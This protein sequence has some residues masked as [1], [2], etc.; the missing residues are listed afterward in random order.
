MPAGGATY[1]HAANRNK[2]S[3]VLDLKDAA[4]LELARRLCERADVVIA[5]FRPGT[6]ERYGL[7]YEQIAAA[8]AGV[9]YCEISGFGEAGGA[10]LPGTTRSSRRSAG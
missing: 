3:L 1:F 10:D 9:V 7:G 4:D 2:R 5:N 8:N 6:L